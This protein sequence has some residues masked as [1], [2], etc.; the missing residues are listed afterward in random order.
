MGVASWIAHCIMMV[1]DG[2]RWYCMSHVSV[3]KYWNLV[4]F[5]L[6]FE[7]VKN[8]EFSHKM[9]FPSKTLH[10]A[11]A[12]E[13]TWLASL[14]LRFRVVR[15][16]ECQIIYTEK[17]LNRL[18]PPLKLPIFSRFSHF[19]TRIYPRDPWHSATLGGCLKEW[20][21]VL[22]STGYSAQSIFYM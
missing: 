14:S 1:S 11:C 22:H 15:V 12:Q 21:M 5:C 13:Q 10:F 9:D 8:L 4:F 16:A 7:H 20:N 17:T 19:F 2:I 18:L 3:G 6:G